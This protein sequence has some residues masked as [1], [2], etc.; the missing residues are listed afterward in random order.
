[1]SKFNIEYAKKL[2]T[3]LSSDRI[4][5]D[6]GGQLGARPVVGRPGGSNFA[7]TPF[8]L[9]IEAECYQNSQLTSTE[10][11]ETKKRVGESS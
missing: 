2:K 11:S 4:Q 5:P 1:M 9:E 7:S 8:L 10:A 6:D 3:L